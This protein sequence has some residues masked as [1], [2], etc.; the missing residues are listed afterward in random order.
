M[1]RRISSKNTQVHN[2]YT[3]SQNSQSWER[4]QPHSPGLAKAKS[5]RNG[6]A[7][8]TLL[9]KTTPKQA[10]KHESHGRDFHVLEVAGS[11]MN[12]EGTR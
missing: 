8:V 2:A 12:K 11:F 1:R 5:S 4:P 10:L 3:A 7:I 6:L 9:M